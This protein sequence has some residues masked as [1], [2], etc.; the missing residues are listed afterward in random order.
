MI[1]KVYIDANSLLLDSFRLAKMIYKSG[2]HPDLLIGLW[3]GGTPAGIAVHEFFVFKGLKPRYHTAIKAESYHG[4]EERGEVC[5]EG[6]DQIVKRAKRG[7]RLLVVDDVFDT[8]KSIEA[9]K[10]VFE[11][12]VPFP[13][14]L[15]VATVYFKPKKNLTNL[16]PDYY[17]KT[18]DDWIVFPHELEGLSKEELRKKGE[19]LFEILNG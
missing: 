6:M 1:K 5:I 10:N 19:V 13:I 8:G 12:N 3:R 11:T 15:K 4:I 16:R 18:I 9:V 7:D 17:L 2:F 14:R